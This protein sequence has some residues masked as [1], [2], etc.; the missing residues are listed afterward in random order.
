[1]SIGLL[2]F[3]AKPQCTFVVFL[4]LCATCNFFSWLL[5]CLFVERHIC[6][7]LSDTIQDDCTLL[8]KQRSAMYM[9]IQRSQ[10]KKI[11]TLVQ[12]TTTQAQET[13]TQVQET[14][15]QAQETT[16]QVQET[17]TQAQKTTSQA[18]VTTTQAQ[19]PTVAMTTAMTFTFGHSKSQ[20]GTRAEIECASMHGMGM[21]VVNVDTATKHNAL[22][23]Y[24]HHSG[25]C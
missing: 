15:T 5:V 18:Q 14:T 22:V 10:G 4:H 7:I 8:H 19:I 21:T 12:E 24:I 23:S 2:V 9:E 11:T 6:A 16:T 3:W 13:T 17:T 25:E 1:M 20:G